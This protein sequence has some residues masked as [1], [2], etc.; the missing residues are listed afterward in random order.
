MAFTAML[1][2]FSISYEIFIEKAYAKNSRKLMLGTV[3]NVVMVKCY[4]LKCFMQV[5]FLI[6]GSE[7]ENGPDGDKDWY[8]T[9]WNK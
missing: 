7:I 2:R 6:G 4:C 9:S 3:W 1:C 5:C 8:L